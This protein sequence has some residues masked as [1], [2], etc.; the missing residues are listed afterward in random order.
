MKPIFEAAKT[1]RRKKRIVYAEGEEERVLRA[2][3]IVV[4]ERLAQ[5]DPGR[6]PGG[7][8]AAHRAVRPA[9]ASADVDF[10][11]VN[12]E[13]DD[14]YRDYWQTYHR[15]TERKGVT[16]STRKIEMRRRHHAD[17]RDDAAQGRGRRHDL[18][19]LGHHRACTCTTSTR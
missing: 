5:A 16:R 7:A 12:P 10:D 6:P 11:V 15:M 18:R 9:P 13:H 14:R 8:R 19:H 2:V 17:R 1:R 3:Q 4:D